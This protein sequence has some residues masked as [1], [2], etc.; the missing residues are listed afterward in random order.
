[1]TAPRMIA[2]YRATDDDGSEVRLLTFLCANYHRYT[3]EIRNNQTAQLGCRMCDVSA[4]VT[5]I[6]PGVEVRTQAARN[7]AEMFGLELPSGYR[8]MNIKY[9]WWCKA[10]H[11]FT[12]TL[13]NLRVAYKKHISSDQTGKYIPCSVCRFDVYAAAMGLRRLDTS[14]SN[15]CKITPWSCIKCGAV[16]K[17]SFDS[18]P[19]CCGV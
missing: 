4:Q 5:N 6:K 11:S 14:H 2:S 1:M 10:G 13:G 9:T 18:R 16:I 3:V 7:M 17:C 8:N 12:S 19:K 15:H